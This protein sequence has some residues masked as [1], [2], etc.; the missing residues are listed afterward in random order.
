MGGRAIPFTCSICVLLKASFLKILPGSFPYSFSSSSG[1]FVLNGEEESSHLFQ[2]LLTIQQFG[3][4]V[5]CF[6]LHDTLEEWVRC[7][8]STTVPSVYIGCA[9]AEHFAAAAVV[10][11]RLCA[12]VSTTQ[13]VQTLVP[14]GCY[15]SS[16]DT[17][18]RG[19]PCIVC[20]S[21]GF[22]GGN[23]R[24]LLLSWEFLIFLLHLGRH[25]WH[26]GQNIEKLSLS[27]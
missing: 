26:K 17:A 23:M 22:T 10:Q 12:L 6:H 8:H 11:H 27:T 9:A 3:Q 1:N 16:R 24:A 20:T 14:L 21:L 25:L 7:T 5:T 2:S 19:S 15:A 18:V 4:T 13:H